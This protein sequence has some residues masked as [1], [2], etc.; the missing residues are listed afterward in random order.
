MA[1]EATD[2]D[3]TR[4]LGKISDVRFT[5]IIGGGTTSAPAVIP[6]IIGLPLL[7]LLVVL[8]LYESSRRRAVLLLLR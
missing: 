6:L 3:E 4:L 5:A 1:A 2:D 8:L 7:P